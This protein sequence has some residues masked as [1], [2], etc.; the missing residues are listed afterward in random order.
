MEKE[1][2]CNASV[3]ESGYLSERRWRH[4]GIL[5]SDRTTGSFVSCRVGV[6]VR[7][8]KGC[9]IRERFS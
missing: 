5:E 6:S 7:E 3:G 2:D 9:S 8:A 1:C 4:K